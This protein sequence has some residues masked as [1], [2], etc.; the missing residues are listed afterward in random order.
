MADIDPDLG[1]CRSRDPRLGTYAA[2]VARCWDTAL[3]RLK[4]ILEANAAPEL[5]ANDNWVRERP[6][7]NDRDK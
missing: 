7:T 3:N 1:R 2:E 6:T 4:A 5:A